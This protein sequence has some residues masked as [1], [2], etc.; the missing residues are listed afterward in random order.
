MYSAITSEQN[1]LPSKQN[2]CK[3][4]NSPTESILIIYAPG[5]IYL[6][7]EINCSSFA[8]N[9]GSNKPTI[10]KWN[11]K[12]MIKRFNEPKLKQQQIYFNSDNNTIPI[13]LKQS[14][15]PIVYTGFT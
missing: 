7:S 2:L 12:I 8:C 6:F 4:L 10:Y 5:T 13:Y 9:I 14:G 3:I 11:G 1:V 15:K